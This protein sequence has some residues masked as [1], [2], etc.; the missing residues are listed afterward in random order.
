MVEQFGG[1]DDVIGGY[2]GP[3][4]VVLDRVA[5]GGHAQVGRVPDGV[6]R[7]VRPAVGETVWARRLERRQRRRVAGHEL[8][9]F[10]VL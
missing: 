2:A 5:Q 4:V 7:A 6:V 3:A 9:P 8:H 10:G 1:F